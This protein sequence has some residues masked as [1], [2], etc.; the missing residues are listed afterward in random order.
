MATVRGAFY[1]F[2]AERII[3]LPG[4]PLVTRTGIEIGLQISREAASSL[5]RLERM[6]TRLQ[7]G[8]PLRLP[9]PSARPLL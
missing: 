8:G 7:V 6:F 3:S 4:Q 9:P 1:E 5:Q 2:H